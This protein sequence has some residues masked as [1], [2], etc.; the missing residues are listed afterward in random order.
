MNTNPIFTDVILLPQFVLLAFHI[1]G[2]DSVLL[3]CY[4][5]LLSYSTF[6][7]NTRLGQYMLKVR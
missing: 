5:V 6:S 1:A 3:R 4:L 7:R 2:V